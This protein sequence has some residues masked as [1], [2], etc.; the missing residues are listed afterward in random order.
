M[1]TTTCTPALQDALAAAV[2]ELGF[3]PLRLPSGAAHDAQMMA[4]L[5]PVGMLFV[6]CRNGIS[7]HPAEFASA[8]D[9]G[10]A[11]AAL[12]RFIDRLEPDKAAP[13]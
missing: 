4:K 3:E 7:H 8:N 1:A 12:I 6:R 9:M 13:A 11:I 10:Y 5:C 2:T